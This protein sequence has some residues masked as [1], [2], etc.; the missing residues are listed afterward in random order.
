MIATKYEEECNSWLPI[1]PLGAIGCRVWKGICIGKD[2][3]SQFIQFK[4]NKGDRVSFWHDRWCSTSSLAQLFPQ[5]YHLAVCKQGS[6]RDH[7]V[8]L[9]ALCSWNLHPRRNLNN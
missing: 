5:C 2:Q 1:S 8:R 4:I 3:L 7:M 9:R 6:V